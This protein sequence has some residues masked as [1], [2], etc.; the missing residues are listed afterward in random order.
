MRGATHFKSA[1]HPLKVCKFME[2]STFR[3]TEKG[4]ETAV[5]PPYAWVILIVVF[6]ASVAAPLNQNKVPP[7]MPVLMDTFQITL[8]Q[9][10]LLMSVFSITGLILALPTGIAL[11]KTGPKLTGLIALGSLVVGSGLGALSGSMGLLLTSRVIEGVG[12]GLIAVVAPAVI[13]A[14]F[15]P[16]KQGTPMGIWATWV[17]VGSVIMMLLAPR[18]ELAA[19]WQSVWWVGAGFALVV[20]ALYGFLMRM[21]PV[22]AESGIVAAAQPRLSYA[23]ANKDIWLLALAFTCFN[24][25]FF[26]L[27]TFFPTFLSE[28]RGYTLTEASTIA[29]VATILVLFS[30]PFAGWLLDHTGSRKWVLTIPF[31]IVAA[32][33]LLPFKVVGWQIYAFMSL[34]GLVAG[35]VPT[36]TFAAAP[37]VMKNPQLA[38]LGLAVIMVGQNL[39]MFIAPVLFGKLVESIGWATAGYWLI[40]VALLG[41]VTGWLV[42]IR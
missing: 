29:S 16:E 34:L 20:F 9:A 3:Q 2:Q 14:W 22:S 11:Q 37:E 42:K 13:A 30:A 21:P 32:M 31:L 26:P 27:T 7:L 19:G 38:G 17:P 23:L 18:L 4:G 15:P 33:L 36:A 39:G 12:M 28:V 6:L 35:F 1:S 10:G 25:V 41:F 8:S 40:P 5:T 24:L